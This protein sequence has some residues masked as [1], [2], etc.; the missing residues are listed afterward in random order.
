[1]SDRH[2]QQPSAQGSSRRQDILQEKGTPCCNPTVLLPV[3]STGR[4]SLP[5]LLPG[6]TLMD[7]GVLSQ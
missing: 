3:P 5:A 4:G 2:P 6:S 1:M 7:V